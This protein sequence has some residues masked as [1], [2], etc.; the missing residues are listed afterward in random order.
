VDASGLFSGS[1]ASGI[2]N[3]IAQAFTPPMRIA[4][5]DDPHQPTLPGDSAF[6]AALVHPDG[7]FSLLFCDTVPGRLAAVLARRAMERMPE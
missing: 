3:A 5:P 1:I 4:A 6:I 2:A 7:R